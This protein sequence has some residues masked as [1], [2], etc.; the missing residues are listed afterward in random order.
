MSIEQIE[1]L[2]DFIDTLLSGQPW[3]IVKQQI[4]D[5]FDNEDKIEDLIQVLEELSGKTGL[6]FAHPFE[7]LRE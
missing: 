2:M 5:S 3:T 1:I 6:E 4:K 7:E